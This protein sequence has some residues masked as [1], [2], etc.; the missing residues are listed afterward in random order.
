VR[1]EGRARKRKERSR[2]V[3]GPFV[4]ILLRH[5]RGVARRKKKKLLTARI[6]LQTTAQRDL[7]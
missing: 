2:A 6:L 3:H 1:G 4:R 7:V 5:S